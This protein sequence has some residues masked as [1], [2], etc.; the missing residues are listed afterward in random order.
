[1]PR[2]APV[3]L[4]V[5]I[6]FTG[7]DDS[8]VLAGDDVVG[9]MPPRTLPDPPDMPVGVLMVCMGPQCTGVNVYVSLKFGINVD[10]ELSIR[11]RPEQSSCSRNFSS[12]Q[13][14]GDRNRIAEQLLTDILISKS[15]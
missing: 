8:G 6:N 9:L 7:G 4:L 15:L 14:S 12:R 2:S 5:R 10:R 11:L 13:I 1:M 3:E